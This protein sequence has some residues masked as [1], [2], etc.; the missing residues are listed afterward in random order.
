MNRFCVVAQVVLLSL[1]SLVLDVWRVGGG[2]LIELQRG[3]LLLLL[4][5]VWIVLL[6]QVK[7]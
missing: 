6:L 5:L 3:H 1:G 7:L 4:L 2:G